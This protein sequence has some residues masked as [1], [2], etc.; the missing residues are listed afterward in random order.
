MRKTR[1]KPIYHASCEGK[2]ALRTL[3][4]CD[5]QPVR[6]GAGPGLCMTVV[7]SPRG[8]A[9][10]IPCRAEPYQKELD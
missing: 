8:C 7:G 1:L 4:V 5:M 3:C 9:L 2:M 6:Q 10:T